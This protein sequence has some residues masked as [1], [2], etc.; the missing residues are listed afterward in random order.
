MFENYQQ[1]NRP[2]QGSMTREG[3]KIDKGL[4]PGKLWL[5]LNHLNLFFFGGVLNL[6]TWNFRDY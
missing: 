2:F 3:D 4:P 5:I 1:E 6:L